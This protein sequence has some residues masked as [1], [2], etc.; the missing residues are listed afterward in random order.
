MS[1][2]NRASFLG[3]QLHTTYPDRT[4]LTR[5]SVT[6]GAGGRAAAGG[7]AHTPQGAL[8]RYALAYVNWDAATLVAHERQLAALAIG[9]ARLA[10]LQTAAGLGAGGSALATHRVRN[11]GTVLAIAPGEGAASGRWVV[12]TQEQTSGTGAYA[13]R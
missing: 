8:R 3:A 6:C 13:G 7:I 5:A 9:P 10:A 4:R 12:V 1:Q 2:A 11:T